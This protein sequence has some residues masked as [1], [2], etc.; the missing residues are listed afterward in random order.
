MCWFPVGFRPAGIR[1]LDILFPPENSALLT[2]GLPTRHQDG[3]DS[4]AVP[5][6]RTHG[7]ATGLGVSFTPQ[8]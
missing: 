4:V 3:P 1:F 7:V 2:V 5:M 6:F 8:G